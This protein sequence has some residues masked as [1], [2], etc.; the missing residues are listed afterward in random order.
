MNKPAI[1]AVLL[2]VALL[3]SACAKEKQYFETSG[4]VF[5]T[6]FHIKYRYTRALDAE[7]K[8]ELDNFDLSLNPFNKQSIIYKVNNNIP[9]ALNPWFEAVFRRAMEISDISG[10]TYDITCA[11]LINLWGFGFDKID[12]VNQAV[13]DSLKEFVGYRKVRL[14]NGAVVKDDPRLQLNASSLAKGYS[15]DVIAEMLDKHG[16]IDYMVEIGGEVR[17]KGLNPHGECWKIQIAKPIDDKSGQINERQEVVAL[18]GRSVATSGNYRN[19]YIKDGKK[20]AHTIN[21]LTGYPAE[22]NILGASVFCAD[23]M[24]ADAFA[25]AFMTMDKDRAVAIAETIPGLDY[26]FIYADV[27]GNLKEAKS[28]GIEFEW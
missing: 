25:T 11:P 22:S 26:L 4:E 28:D 23:C 1:K 20:I 27:D 15:C 2:A 19:F 18:C 21:P 9:T 6:S 5:H 7:I 16:V 24:S 14:E 17:A 8:V 3:F 10:G 13:I 12:S